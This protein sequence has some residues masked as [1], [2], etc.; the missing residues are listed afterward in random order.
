MGFIHK[1]STKLR[2]NGVDGVELDAEVTME[3]TMEQ[4]ISWVKEAAVMAQQMRA[5]DLQ[6][7]HKS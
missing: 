2:V 6:V 3:P 4:V 5:E 7:R 1:F